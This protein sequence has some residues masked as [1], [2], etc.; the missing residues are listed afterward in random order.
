FENN[1]AKSGGALAVEDG[2]FEASGNQGNVLFKENTAQRGAAISAK[3]GVLKFSK[4]SVG[5]Y[6][7]N[8]QNGN[9]IIE[10]LGN[11][12]LSFPN[13][14]VS[15]KN[16]QAKNGGFLSLNNLNKTMEIEADA[17]IL[18][19]NKAAGTG[20][21]LNIENAAIIIS[22]KIEADGNRALKEGGAVYLKNAVLEF[23]SA[24]HS[25]F[26]D[27]ISNNVSADAKGNDFYLD[28]NSEVYFNAQ[29]GAI[30]LRSG[31]A[32]VENSFISKTGAKDLILS[33]NIDF[34][35]KTSVEEGLLKINAVSA[36]FGSVSI[37][38]DASFA[39]LP[40]NTSSFD[41]LSV[42]GKYGEF[43]D[44]KADKANQSNSASEIIIGEKSVFGLTLLNL[45][46]EKK[47]YRIM[48]AQN[49]DGRFGIL[50]NIYPPNVRY[51]LDY[52]DTYINLI[53]SPYQIPNFALSHN[54]EQIKNYF[55]K[56][57]DAWDFASPDMKE[58]INA[59]YQSDTQSAQ[60]EF[61]GKFNADIIANA[62]KSAT[63]NKNSAIAFNRLRPDL[64]SYE[65][66]QS[67]WLKGTFYHKKTDK[68]ENSNG[69]F[70]YDEYSALLGTD[71][72]QSR[73]ML[74]G[75]YAEIM[76]ADLKEGKDSG[77][78]KGIGLG[79]YLF[80]PLN[81]TRQFNI[82][83][84]LSFEYQDFN[85][86]REIELNGNKYQPESAFNTKAIKA[87]IEIE[88]I[89]TIA[90]FNIT[91]FIGIQG[92][93]AFNNAFE[94][95]SNSPI[96]LSI[97]SGS[98]NSISAPFGISADYKINKVW[99]ARAKIMGKT[100][101]S[102]EY[103]QISADVKEMPLKDLKLKGTQENL[104][105]GA[106][107]GIDYNISPLFALTADANI[108]N[109]E[110]SFGLGVVYKVGGKQPAETVENK[111]AEKENG[112][113]VIAG[114]NKGAEK[115]IEKE[116]KSQESAVD[117]A[118]KKE[119]EKEELRVLVA[120]REERNKKAVEK[121]TLGAANFL[122]GKSDLTRKAKEKL[123]HQIEK[124]NSL[125][126]AKIV[127]E[128][129]TDA[130]GNDDFNNKLSQDRAQS[131]YKEFASAGIA[132]EKMEC[133]GYG[134]KIP[135]SDNKTYKGREA[136]RRIEVWALTE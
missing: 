16:N 9:G 82:K 114:Y 79:L 84:A 78:T 110:Y 38:E 57:V 34:K 7:N 133:I 97:Q 1:S 63:D 21:A 122:T 126:Y 17:F 42:F 99:T 132:L 67:F 23:N 5:F 72:M 76:Q 89:F 85:I 48:S 46:K 58:L 116:E 15:A 2:S 64:F 86:K 47:T 68:D 77:N 88:K 121:I 55:E 61:F 120:I 92:G 100:I 90:S 73:K 31:I 45:P 109:S 54:K 96:N 127:I 135:V 4:N 111:G 101:L 81:N 91:P 104:A 131:V 80:A 128:G 70:L 8:S 60:E 119:N 49:I 20:G 130:R 35:G 113:A 74:I 28:N 62:L 36:Q 75:G 112:K 125:Q 25:I 30:D 102:G 43:V 59:A 107:I 69:D 118:E 134:S 106:Q 22:G 14:I 33:G 41:A 52:Q 11:S 95:Q 40:D 51:A 103:G 3:N 50:E 13:S 10:L 26:A 18:Q 71:I 87:A 39:T 29:S 27:N 98:N 53:I 123:R 56:S 108:A 32:G 105:Y 12:V 94:E 83:S 24:G 44:I 124:L 65:N 37:N 6:S 129:H 115:K 117:E 93:F 66:N 136:N 19:E